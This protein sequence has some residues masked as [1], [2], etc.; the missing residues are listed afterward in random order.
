MVC[1]HLDVGLKASVACSQGLFLG[2][3][4]EAPKASQKPT[5]GAV[6]WVN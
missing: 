4:G 5:Y 6:Q 2:C 1:T 3:S